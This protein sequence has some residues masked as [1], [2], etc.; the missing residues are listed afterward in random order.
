MKLKHTVEELFA[1]SVGIKHRRLM[2][3]ACVSEVSDIQTCFFIVIDCLI[4]RE[5]LFI[6]NSKYIDRKVDFRSLENSMSFKIKTYFINMLKANSKTM[7]YIILYC[8]LHNIN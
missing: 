2:L 5:F 6:L 4:V 1:K 8:K 3:T 7:Q